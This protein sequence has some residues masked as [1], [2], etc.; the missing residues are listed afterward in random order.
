MS[1]NK[2][3]SATAIRAVCAILFVAFATHYIYT[4]QGDVLAMLQHSLS[5]GATHYDR[6]IGCVIIVGVAFALSWLTACVVR[7]PARVHALIYVPASLLL[8]LLTAV[9]AD[10]QGQAAARWGW[11][12]V[13]AL[14]L[15]VYPFVV[16]T[17]RDY[18][19]F[20]TPQ[21]GNAFL[22]HPWWTNAVCLVITCLATAAIGN[23]SRTLHIRLAVERHVVEHDYAAALATGRPEYD[24]DASL[25]M[26]RAIALAHTGGLGDSLFTYNISRPASLL[27]VGGDDKP[28]FLLAD[29]YAAWQAIGFVPRT[30]HE[31]EDVILRRELS[32]HSCPTLRREAATHLLLCHYLIQKDLPAFARELCRHYKAGDTLPRHYAEAM[33]I[34]TAHL[35]QYAGTFTLPPDVMADYRDMLAVLRSTNDT[36]LRAARLRDT[37]FGTYWCYYFLR[38]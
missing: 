1:T 18:Q 17:A 7:L 22:S 30:Q 37:F 9:D 13:G 3:N 19:P 34:A 4:V 21:R 29:P 36:T 26:L 35:P 15:A 27:P 6:R 2:N 8:G 10:G 28:R 25:T 16:R 14:L 38:K 32:R 23:N 20:L 33:A 11:T 31:T 24:N 12:A 5:G